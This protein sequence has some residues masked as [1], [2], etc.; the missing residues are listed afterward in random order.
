M[1]AYWTACPFYNPVYALFR[2]ALHVYSEAM[3]VREFAA[4][5]LRSDLRD[6]QKIQVFLVMWIH[7]HRFRDAS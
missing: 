5:C 4:T 6:T 3:R 7:S 2:R 1:A